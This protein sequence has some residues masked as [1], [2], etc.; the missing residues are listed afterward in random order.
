MLAAQPFL[1][2][3]F[4]VTTACFCQKLNADE[5]VVALRTSPGVPPLAVTGHGHRHYLFPTNEVAT[6]NVEF[7]GGLVLYFGGMIY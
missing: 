2:E 3:W 6:R 1:H 4:R 5:K 7:F